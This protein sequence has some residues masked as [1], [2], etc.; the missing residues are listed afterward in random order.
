MCEN[1][2]RRFRL[3]AALTIA[4]FLPV[5]GVRAQA[6][7]GG[8]VSGLVTDPTGAAVANAT[9]SMRE[10][11]KQVTHTTLTDTTGHYVF[12]NLAV[13][14]YQL[15]IKAQGFKNYIQTGIVVQVGSSASANV[16]MQL[17]S[18]SQ[19]VEVQANA[20]MVETTNSNVSQVIDEKQVN[21]L[22]LNGR[23]V[24]QLVLLSG[25]AVTVSPAQGDLTGSKNFY[26]STTI[27]VGGGQ[28]NATNYLLDGGYNVDT[29]TNVN[30]PFPFPD[31]LQEF[32]VET[33]T[34]PAQYGEHP[35]GVMNAVT[36][37][38]RSGQTIT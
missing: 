6:V 10:T 5:A 2:E 16:T 30:R 27:S 36:C 20:S 4:S 24:T 15:E 18:I 23:Y 32:S 13:G 9:V 11:D 19:N 37:K 35:G 17:G 3:I 28:A 26:S 8:S 22:P 33:S 12:N 29:F 31:A 21:D 14:P 38:T 7:A 25:A 34:L 1:Y